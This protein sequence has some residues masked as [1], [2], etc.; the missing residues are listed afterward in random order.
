MRDRSVPLSDNHLIFG[1]KFFP[2]PGITSSDNP[3]ALLQLLA[4]A[5]GRRPIPPRSPS[6]MTE[7]STSAVA[8]I[9]RRG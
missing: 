5:S 8:S 3:L 7:R 6:S 4:V 2:P 1:L 9:W